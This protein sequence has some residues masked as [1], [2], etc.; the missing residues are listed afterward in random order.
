MLL[1]VLHNV[2]LPIKEPRVVCQEEASTCNMHSTPQFHIHS[3]DHKKWE[4][5]S[6]VISNRLSVLPWLP[7][8]QYWVCKTKLGTVKSSIGSRLPWLH[9]RLSVTLI[10]LVQHLNTLRYP[11]SALNISKTGVES[12]AQVIISYTPT[13]Q[14]QT[15][16]SKQVKKGAPQVLHYLHWWVSR[17]GC[18]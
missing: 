2:W 3:C 18:S 13:I 6:A 4:Y 5:H 1:H 7:S 10:T 14:A 9:C 15:W 12:V 11:R 8:V 16:H 17:V